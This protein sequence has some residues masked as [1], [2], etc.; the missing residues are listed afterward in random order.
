MTDLAEF[1]P[2]EPEIDGG[3][4]CR[5]IFAR[6][7]AEPS[8]FKHRKLQEPPRDL[9]SLD[10]FVPLALVLLAAVLVNIL[11]FHVTM[12]PSGLPLPLFVTLLWLIVALPLRSH[13][14]PLFAQKAQ[15]Q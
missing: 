7:Y 8:G 11:A 3:S 6:A 1:S 13:F 12:M 9:P 14:A 15:P 4:A 2:V 10:G 5:D